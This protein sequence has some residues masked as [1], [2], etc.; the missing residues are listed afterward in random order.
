[1]RVMKLR[2]LLRNLYARCDD[3]VDDDVGGVIGMRDNESALLQNNH[4]TVSSPPPSLHLI[5]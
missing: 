2:V 3:V 4:E 5:Q 1:M